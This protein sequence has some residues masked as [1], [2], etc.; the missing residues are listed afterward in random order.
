MCLPYQDTEWAEK[1]DDDKALG[2]AC[3]RCYRISRLYPLLTLEQFFDKL[4]EDRGLRMEVESIRIVLTNEDMHPVF[5]QL[6]G[7]EA[8]RIVGVRVESAFF[9]FNSV[10]FLQELK[11]KA[12]TL[13][14]SFKPIEN[15][16]LAMEMVVFVKDE[17][18]PRRAIVFSESTNKMT[19][20]MMGRQLRENQAN[21]RLQWLINNDLAVR[22]EALAPGGHKHLYTLEEIRA[23]AQALQQGRAAAAAG[24]F[25]SAPAAPARATR[26]AAEL[27]SWLAG[28]SASSSSP[29]QFARRP[30]MPP[31]PPVARVA[32]HPSPSL[33]PPCGAP[34]GERP[35]KRPRGPQQACRAG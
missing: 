26:A 21:D 13:G 5:L 17:T 30:P 20:Q 32:P 31:V 1:S 19:L 9:M 6:G 4:K 35:A 18:H 34:A 7:V 27:P 23:K 28:Q 29:P 11:V 8:D 15:E 12:E 14:L 24:G 22:T 2:A 3:L 16:A 25:Q 10:E 33:R